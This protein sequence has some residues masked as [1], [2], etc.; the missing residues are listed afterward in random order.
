MSLKTL[1][2]VFLNHKCN[3]ILFETIFSFST[4]CQVNLKWLKEIK[5]S[6][7]MNKSKVTLNSM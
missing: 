1:K 6:E 7:I 4:K 5:T 3:I 2:V